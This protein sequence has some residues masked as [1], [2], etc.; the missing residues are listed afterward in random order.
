MEKAR[1]WRRMAIMVALSLCAV[2]GA[3]AADWPQFLGPDRNGIAPDGVALPEKWGDGVPRKLWSVSVGRGYAGPAIFGDSVLILDREPSRADVLRRLRLSD[4]REVWRFRYDAPGKV[5]YPGS[6]STPAT[7]GRLV[8]TIG[9][10]GHLHAVRFDD[11]KPVWKG[12]IL[13][14]WAAGRP[15]WGVATSP[16]LLGDLVIVAP[17]GR[18]A[19]VVAYAKTTGKV[20]WATPNPRGVVQEYQSP[21]PMTLDGRTIIVATGRRGYAIGVDA[22]TGKQLW[23]YTGY[24]QRGW[25]IPSPIIVGEGRVLI[26]G[27]YG[28]GSA[29]FKVGRSRGPRLPVVE[30]WKSRNLGTK[31]AQALVYKGYIYGNSSDVRGGLRCL[32][33]DGAIVWDSRAQRRTFEM[34][35]LLIA[36]GKIFILNGRGGRLHMVAASPDGYKELGSV[37]LLSGQQVWAPLAYSN[38]RLLVRDLQKLVCLDLR[39]T[40]K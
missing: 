33:L 14:D 23:S 6:R 38:G 21:V 36:D 8:F 3:R 40:P 25:N 24:P 19:A 18:K 39:A 26:T 13:R 7:D 32:T 16:L 5:Q 20:V 1:T 2:A 34:G 4:G 10:F 29:M 37:S 17:W 15:N 27:G 9:P 11:G 35:N 12:H 30:L 22:K 31:I 28:C